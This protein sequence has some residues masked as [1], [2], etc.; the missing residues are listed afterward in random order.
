VHYQS[1]R[2]LAI[3]ALDLAHEAFEAAATEL[4]LAVALAPDALGSD[5]LI[6]ARA[7]ELQTLA[8]HAAIRR[9]Y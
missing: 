3:L 7:I 5:A 1:K 9:H 6:L 2:T 4:T 8:V